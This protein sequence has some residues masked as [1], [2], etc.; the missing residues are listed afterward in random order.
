MIKLKIFIVIETLLASTGSDKADKILGLFY[1]RGEA[2]KAI[3]K[4]KKR[5]GS[6]AGLCRI[7]KRAVK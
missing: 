2:K 1:A 4:N 3:E 7:E 5:Y 6:W